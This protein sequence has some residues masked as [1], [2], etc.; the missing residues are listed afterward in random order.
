MP[1]P[2]Y[3]PP[4]RYVEHERRLGLAL[5]CIWLFIGTLIYFWPL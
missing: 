3:D 1:N 5:V 2:S 4:N